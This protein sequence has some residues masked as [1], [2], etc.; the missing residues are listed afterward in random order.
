VGFAPDGI[1]L[2][3]GRTALRLPFPQRITGPETLRAMLKRLVQEARE[4]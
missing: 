4:K 1:E 2:Q 3:K